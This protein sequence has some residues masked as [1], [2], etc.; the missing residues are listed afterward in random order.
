MMKHFSVLIKPA[1]SLCN[2]NCKYCFY[3]DVT[4]NRDTKSYGVMPT[5]TSH[6]LIDRVYEFCK[7]QTIINFA[8][9]GGEPLVAGIEYFDDFIAYANLKN[10]KNHKINF[11]LQTNGTL[12]NEDWCTLFKKFH[13]LIGVS[14][15]GFERIHN[16]NRLDYSDNKT[17]ELIMNNIS[18]LKKHCIDFNILTV[19]TKELSAYP[20]ELF[21]FYKTND[22]KYIQLI[23]CLSDLDK[24]TEYALTPKAF[25]KFYNVFF[26]LWFKELQ[27][28]NYISVTYFENII[29]LFAGIAPSQCG[30]LGKC[31]LQFVIEGN[32]NV[33]PCDFY[34][35]DKYYLGNIVDMSIEEL[36][37][38][39]KAK[40]FLLE[41]KKTCTRCQ[42]CQFYSICF[43]QCKRL[44]TC[45][46]DDDYCGLEKF[47]SRNIDKI[48]EASK[49]FKN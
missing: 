32:G 17:H 25:Y 31:T 20:N 18:L 12:I 9:Q 35:Y 29:P 13:F 21:D 24:E 40:E 2:L 4:T 3:H 30:Y 46:Y 33:Y 16:K 49:Y 38:S 19:L 47:M 7:E 42:K 26:Q 23:P 6:Q 48:L 5:E 22:F 37:Q 14:L 34:A 10:T 45:Y 8:F 28:G 15:D 27:K 41:N 1:S 43:G 44:S 36:R 11:I 39:P